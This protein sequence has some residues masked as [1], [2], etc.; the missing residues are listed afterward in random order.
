MIVLP[1]EGMTCEACEATINGKVTSMA[2]VVSCSASHQA[3]SATIV[4]DPSRVTLDSLVA[5]IGES[6]YQASLPN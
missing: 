2:G 6:G 3:K 1:V 5:A 4:Y